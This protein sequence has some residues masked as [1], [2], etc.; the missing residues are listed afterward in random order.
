MRRG[1]L[2]RVSGWGPK[3]VALMLILALAPGCQ[4]SSAQIAIPLAY[5]LTGLCIA[6]LVSPTVV[7]AVIGLVVGGI[8]GAAVYN[9]SLKQEI[10]E[11]PGQPPAP[12]K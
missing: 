5:A 3:M 1:R 8:L 4:Y 2:S 6:L 7:A 12:A 11:N 10:Q 9:N